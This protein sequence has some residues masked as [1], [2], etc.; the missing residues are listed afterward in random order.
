MNYKT[1][2]ELV[3]IDSPSGYTEKACHYIFDLLKGYGWNPEYTNKGAVKCALGKEPV[4]G[5]AA[6][7][8]TLGA[9]VTK[10]NDNGTLKFS[11][12]GGPSLNAY[13]GLLFKGAYIKRQGLQ[14]HP[15]DQ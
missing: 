12:V 1:L 9:V 11:P 10:I 4:L 2:Q 3:A 8:D 15:A 6:H 5:I 7:V 13:R 14:W